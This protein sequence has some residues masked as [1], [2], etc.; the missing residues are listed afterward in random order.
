MYVLHDIRNPEAYGGLPGNPRIP[1][2]V[3]L[4]KGPMKWLGGLAM[5]F[6]LVGIVGHFLR[7]GPK[8][9]HTIE[10]VHRP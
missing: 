5:T 1:W 7:F 2:L 8:E 6:G 10:E 9:A 4:W 3:S